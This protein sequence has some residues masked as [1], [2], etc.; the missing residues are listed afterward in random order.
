MA[1]P[2]TFS[3]QI[4]SKRYPTLSGGFDA[5]GKKFQRG[6][7]EVQSILKRELL[8]F[9]NEIA[10]EM[11]AKHS[12]RWPSGTGS[13]SLSSRTGKGVKSIRRSIVVSGESL[14]DT[15]GSMGASPLM[16]LHETGA[17]IKPTNKKYMAIPLDAAMDSRGV[18]KRIS[19]RDWDRTFVSRAKSGKLFIFRKVGRRVVPM[20]LL[21]GAGESQSSVKI[22]ARLGMVNTARKGMDAFVERYVNKLTAEMMHDA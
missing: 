20:Y 11:E 19:P 12:G 6:K 22:P 13:D 8:V 3:I 14:A 18:P 16:A 15:K 17:E 4:D 5:L 1:E 9:L 21:I 2:V 10:T 7:R